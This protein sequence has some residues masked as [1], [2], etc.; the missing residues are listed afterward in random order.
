MTRRCH[1]QSASSPVEDPSSPKESQ[2]STAST[3]NYVPADEEEDMDLSSD[4]GDDIVPTS[5]EMSSNPAEGQSRDSTP[6]LSSS[7]DTSDAET[8]LTDWSQDDSNNRREL[9]GSFSEPPI[10]L[11]VD[12][13]L[14]REPHSLQHRSQSPLFLPSPQ[15]SPRPRRIAKF[16]ASVDAPL[17]QKNEDVLLESDTSHLFCPVRRFLDSLRRPCGHHYTTF[18]EIGVL[19]AESGPEY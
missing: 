18:Y 1:T 9:S 13:L 19:L 16:A 8:E 14:V 6:S 11:E 5:R 15:S 10:F 7:D 3:P 17:F 4:C 12:G 2:P